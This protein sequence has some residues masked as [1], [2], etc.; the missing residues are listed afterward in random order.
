MG[1]CVMLRRVQGTAVPLVTVA[2]PSLLELGALV[3]RW[4]NCVQ[5][6]PVSP[7]DINQGRNSRVLSLTKISS[8]QFFLGFLNQDIFLVH[9]LSLSKFFVLKYSKTSGRRSWRN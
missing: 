3:V 9:F 2:T 1:F 4:D 8:V 6:D 5:T 7:H